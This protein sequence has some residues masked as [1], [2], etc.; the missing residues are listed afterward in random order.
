MPPVNSGMKRPGKAIA[1]AAFARQPVQWPAS[2]SAGLASCSAATVA[3]MRASH[4][5]LTRCRP[6]ATV[7]TASQTSQRIKNILI[8]NLLYKILYHKRIC[9]MPIIYVIFSLWDTCLVRRADKVQAA[10]HGVQCMP[11]VAALEDVSLW[12][13]KT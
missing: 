7:C 6:P 10:R 9:R 8:D 1:S 12:R 2:T 3:G 13:M 5:G 4:G 11:Q